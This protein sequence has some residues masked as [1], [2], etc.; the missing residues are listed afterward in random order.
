MKTQL[1][2][3]IF[4]LPFATII[5][6]KILNWIIGFNDSTND[7]INKAMFIFIGVSYLIFGYALDQLRYRLITMVCGLI[8]ITMN[9]FP[10]ND[11][12]NALA[13][14]SMLVAIL[15]G[16]LVVPKDKENSVPE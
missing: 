8:L 3:L 6:A 15:I 13:I 10:K 5:L 7:L 9:F 4:Y 12:T 2:R 11:Y 16:R 14:S 1:M